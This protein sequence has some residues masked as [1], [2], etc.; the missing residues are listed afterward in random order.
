MTAALVVA[1]AALSSC[2][3]S[4]P[5]PSLKT[6]IDTLSYELGMVMSPGDQL[7]MM[8]TQAGSDSSYVD[9]YAKGFSEGL[10]TAEDKKKFAYYM[11]VLQGIQSKK[12]MPQME[13]QIFNND[14]TKKFSVK[15]FA[16]GYIALTKGKTALKKDGKL[17]DR[18]AAQADLMAYMFKKQQ[19]ESEAYIAAKAREKGVQKLSGGVLYKVLTPSN[20]T[21]RVST[22]DSIIVKY[23]GSLADGTVFDSS[24]NAP[25]GTVTLSLARTIEG[26]KIAVPQM[27]IG[28]TWELYIPADKAYGA[29]G[30]G[31][32]PP[33]S[34]LTFTITLVSKK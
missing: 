34:A 30:M 21:E 1:T 6:Q 17:V 9:E 10:R 31:S 26:W 29:Q 4:A 19:K 27:P 22:S 2:G 5:K 12:Q 13:S 32:V 16:A 33:Y 18:E 11:G 14:S 3:G 25:G 15:N 24:E 7:P 20:S 23:K 28:A 8:L